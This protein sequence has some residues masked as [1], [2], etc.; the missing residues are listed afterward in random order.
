MKAAKKRKRNPELVLL[1]NPGE[2]PVKGARLMSHRVEEIDYRHIEEE[3]KNVVRYH[4][5]GRNVEMWA[6]PSGDVLLR[7]SKGRPLWE[8]F[9]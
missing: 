7:H 4:P 8:D 2:A 5:F 3:G 1:L 9:K 6:L